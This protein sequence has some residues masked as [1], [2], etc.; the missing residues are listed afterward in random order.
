MTID[1]NG[2]PQSASV[3][4]DR[5]HVFRMPLDRTT[6]PAKTLK[7]LEA[8]QEAVK[9]TEKAHGPK[10]QQQAAD[11]VR[12]AVGDLYDRASSTSRADRQLHE[13]GFAYS[14]AKFKRA[15]EDAE[16][17]LQGMADHAQQADNPVGVGFKADAREKSATVVQLHLIADV[18]KNMPA[19]PELG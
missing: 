9:G 5:E 1:F 15:I 17:A 14:A 3:A 11:A 7:A 18:L 2:S 16:A 12:D 6:V 19:V 13:E 8:V 4:G 10:A